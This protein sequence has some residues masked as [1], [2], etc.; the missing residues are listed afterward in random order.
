MVAAIEIYPPCFSYRPPERRDARFR[1]SS[2]CARTAETAVMTRVRKNVPPF[3]VRLSA[4]FVNAKTCVSTGFLR[5]FLAF[6]WKTGFFRA[7]HASESLR[8]A[9]GAGERDECSVGAASDVQE[10]C[11]RL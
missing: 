8:T 10:L 2:V 4:G 7:F 11:N 5:F 1:S 6:L 3:T 9:F